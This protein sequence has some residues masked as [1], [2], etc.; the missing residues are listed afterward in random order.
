MLSDLD[1]RIFPLFP[2]CFLEVQDDMRHYPGFCGNSNRIGFQ[3]L[4]SIDDAGAGEF[5][6]SHLIDSF[7]CKEFFFPPLNLLF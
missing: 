4:G 5:F 2:D 7:D 6:N 1:Y 3:K